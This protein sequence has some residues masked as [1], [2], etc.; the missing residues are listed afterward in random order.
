MRAI[1]RRVG[2]GAGFLVCSALAG[3]SDLTIHL[4]GSQP[5]TRNTAKYQCDAQGAKMGLPAEIFSVEYINGAGNSLAVVPVGGNSLIFANV[6]SGSGAR[7]AAGQ[8][9]WW[10]AGGRGTT[11]SSGSIAGKMSSACHRVQ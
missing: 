8:Y 6:V 5:I 9:I 7:Y 10:D 11:F 2:V 1:W 3:A 4:S